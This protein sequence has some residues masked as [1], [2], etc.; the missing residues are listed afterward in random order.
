M[1]GRLLFFI[2]IFLLSTALSPGCVKRQTTASVVDWEEKI[3]TMIVKAEQLGARECSPRELARAKVLLEHAV[4]E[5]EEGFYPPSWSGTKLA[6][7]ERMA[8][9]LLEK[10][11][12]AQKS[13]FPFRCYHR[14]G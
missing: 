5:R 13:G 4:H 7:V 8:H 6:E 14:K 1:R 10:R 2:G 9:E 3:A 12:M 11:I